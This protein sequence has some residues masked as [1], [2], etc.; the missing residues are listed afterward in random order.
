VLGSKKRV[1]RIFPSRASERPRSRSIF[2]HGLEAVD[3]VPVKIL[4][5]ND[6]PRFPLLLYPR[7]ISSFCPKYLSFF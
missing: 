2:L 5:G 7:I 4:D 3:A 6:V 1:A